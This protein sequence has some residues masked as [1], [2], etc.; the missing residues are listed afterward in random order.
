MLLSLLLD[1]ERGEDCWWRRPPALR[2]F[3]YALFHR[4]DPDLAEALHAG[5]APRPFTLGAWEQAER[6]RLRLTALSE[7]AACALMEAVA[8]LPGGPPLVM[9]DASITALGYAVDEPP[10]AGVTTYADLAQSRFQR[11]VSLRFPAP[12][13]FSHGG[14]VF[15]PLP[16]PP[17]MLRSWGRRWNEF[18]PAELAVPEAVV[19]G[20]ISRIALAAARIETASVSLSPGRLVGFTGSATLEAQRPETWLGE[21]RAAFACLT[22]FSRYSGTGARTTQGMG[23]TL[24]DGRG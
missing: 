4:A 11:S 16:Y 9:G 3:A 22:A 24:P 13:T 19:A 18:A 5:D 8:E 14:E 21:E 6:V 1:L 10:Y 2:A 15:I 12:T 23:V 17:L 20:V 7:A